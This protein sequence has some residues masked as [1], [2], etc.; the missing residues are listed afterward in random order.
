[1]LSNIKK[2]KRRRHI[3][4]AIEIE[5]TLRFNDS[6]SFP[7]FILDF[8][9]GGFYLGFKQADL[10]IPPVKAARIQFSI[11]TGYAPENFE[12][13]AKIVHVTST[14][15]GVEFEHMP[16]ALLNALIKAVDNGTKILLRDK[17]RSSPNTI[18][19]QNSKN[20]LKK[21]LV[22]QLPSLMMRFYVYIVEDLENANEHA[23]YFANRSAFDDFITTLK[24]GRES[25][26]SEFCS[27]VVSQVDY[28]SESEDKKEDILSV[29]MP[30]SLVDKEDFEDWLNMSEIVRALSNH[31][32]DQINQLIRALSRVF[33]L[34]TFTVNNPISPA[35]LCNCFRE[36]IL[37]QEFD[38]NLYKVVYRC[39][40]KT[41]F[42]SLIN[43]YEQVE[44]VLSKQES[45]EKT[46][47]PLPTESDKNTYKPQDLPPENQNIRIQGNRHLPEQ[48]AHEPDYSERNN[49]PPVTQIAG[50]LLDIL[51]EMDTS[52][53]ELIKKSLSN[54]KALV[55]ASSYPAISSD[56][57]VAAISNIQHAM[58]DGGPIHLDST[59][60][61]KQL[62][63]NLESLGNK[64]NL[65]SSDDIRHLEI[66]GKFF[67]TLFNDLAFSVEIKSYLDSIHL[68]LLS[69]PFQGSDFLESDSHP[70][71]KILN[72]LAFLDPMVKSNRVIKN[73]NIKNTLDKIISRIARE[74]NANPNIF[75][76][77][78]QELD[79]LTQQVSKSID[80]NIKHIVEVY[81][82]RQKLEMA[83]CSVQNEVDKRIAGKAVPTV[84]PALLKAGWQH[85]LV[86]AELNKDTK[87][88]EYRKYWKALDDLFFWLYEQDSV[89]KIQSGSIQK[90]IEF[91]G[92]NLVSVCT[93]VT[94]R[95]TIIE[96][97][98]ALLLGVGT[99]KVRSP[100]R[101]VKI[102][103]LNSNERTL[104]ELSDGSWAQVEQL[105]VGDWL[106]ML[107]GPQGFE[108]MKLVWKGTFLRV[109]VFV[110]RDGLNKM[111]LNNIELAERF[112]SGAANKMD[113][114]DIPVVDRATN[115]MLQNMHEKLVHNA[116]HDHE[117]DLFT[118]DEFV[119]Q[120]R[121]E[122][123]KLSN[124]QHML[125]HM[126]VLDFRVIT[127]ICGLVGGAQ[128]IKRISR[129]IVEQLKT[130]NIAARIGDQS[131]A[132]LFK[133]CSADEGYQFCKQLIKL[134]NDS[135]FEWLE[136]SFPIGVSLGLVAFGDNCYDIH[137]LLQQAD[138]ASLSAEHSGPNHV[139]MF[140]SDDES[141]KRQNKL[142]E[143]I[144]HID[145][146]L[147]Q[148]RL[149]IRCQ[150][151]APV[152]QTR[153]TH[154]H[155]EILLGVRD[156]ADN[157]IPPDHFIP[158]V[159]RCKRM[160]EI[161]EWIIR[162]VF[163]W[164][165]QNRQDFINMDGFSINLSGQSINS[166]E[167]LEFLRDFL[168]SS[169]IPL[170]KITFEITETV[171][172]ESLAFTKRFIQAIKQFGCKFSL[173]DFGSGYSSY[174]YLK[175]LSVDY[176]K[177]DGAFVKDIAN[178]KADIAIV[179]SMNEIAHSLGLKTIAEYVENNEIREILR[180]IGVD[181]VQ[182]YGIQKPIFLT[183]LVIE[184]PASE[185]FYFEDN[186][187][188][189][190]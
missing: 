141:L 69:L 15:L 12:I 80:S 84:I 58:G 44:S 49:R 45:A 36:I 123:P 33:G 189:E 51:N 30:L 182:G 32:E 19:Q 47:Q 104:T 124:S 18:K 57:I 133:H 169:T 139:L 164:I 2:S 70:A 64:A 152:D 26:I 173:D 135:H 134:I 20:A 98:T 72:Q 127:S 174:S 66:Y 103:P 125:C 63:D 122:L 113:N 163:I 78:G 90:T 81:D 146:V 82:G 79:G 119:K 140:N 105:Q 60:L 35:V 31:F 59:A 48:Q 16:D 179:K 83:R 68:S 180:Q 143:W 4:Y 74:S 172:A 50:K 144:G 188:W 65:L 37:R 145:N 117:T 155:Y 171:A 147:S 132:V 67:E 185:A 186:A 149:F 53:L 91:F 121:N 137:Q 176:L 73:I 108:P 56:Q 9:D 161:D 38:A 187:F 131:F 111:E 177:I 93:S 168:A 1:M 167:F 158:A 170:D 148:N 100:V 55:S 102:P 54:D 112:R 116:T 75:T 25:V 42:N 165:E 39:F 183:D 40:G 129:I 184:A 97:L 138:T 23:Q 34:S 92:E 150:R 95:K 27:L 175:N 101:T 87:P 88:D 41:L 46:R 62:Q 178:N 160:P 14:G 128:L 96:E 106:M 110:N 154:Q 43:L 190:I 29:D 157:I 17:R 153:Q 21:I 115:I 162:N 99:P 13:D 126:E 7:C 10:Q 85:L 130:D 142:Y 8:C 5:A 94:E 77:V 114:L 107:S 61:Q 181:Y 3:R 86:M 118:K 151:I 6:V 76:E 52:S 156:D 166:E 136:K 89:V 28:I 109:Y 22:D 159:E 120:L 11:N 71:R 24:Q